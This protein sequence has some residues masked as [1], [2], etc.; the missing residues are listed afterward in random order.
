MNW[1]LSGQMVV[2]N[3]SNLLPFYE[4]KHRRVLVTTCFACLSF[5]CTPQPLAD[6]CINWAVH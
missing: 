2:M 6:C 4:T 1:G 3:V 5:P